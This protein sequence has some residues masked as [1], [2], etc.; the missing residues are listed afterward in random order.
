MSQPNPVLGA[1]NRVHLAYELLIANTSRLFITV[2]KVEA[3]DLEGRALWSE[4]G[5]SLAAM[6]SA[7][8]GT[9]TT[10]APGSSV[11]VLMDVPFGKDDKL[12]EQ[13]MARVTVTR[14]LA[15][16]DG[17][18]AAYPDSEPIPKTVS[19]TG[20]ATAI[21]KP[22][23]LIEPPLRG[24]GWFAV[25]GCCDSMTSHRGAVMAVNGK[26]RVPERFAIDWIKLDAQG[27]VFTGDAATLTSY[28]YFG[29]PVYAVADGV[30]V[31]L[32]DQADEQVPGKISGITTE[33]IGGNMMVIDI[34]DGAYAFYAHLQ[35]DS[36]K[37]KLG[38][39]VT[40]GDVVGLLG[41]TGNTT[42]P[43][44]HFHLMDGTSPLDANGLSYVFSKFTT[45]GVVTMSGDNDPIEKGDPAK[46]TDDGYTGA[47]AAQLPL[48]NQVVDFPE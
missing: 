6:T 41:N 39:R 40:T 5:D 29:A 13:V 26:L 10:M 19:F 16:Q 1:D 46:I 14:A 21:G 42:A 2:D 28:A 35:R 18:P 33:N 9:G 3:V 12:P 27:R 4:D 25:N 47:H 30:V 20:A 22:A 8:G 17:K 11:V 31:N 48:N 7:Y 37:F 44:L 43:H 36:L 15:G 32:Y 23:R 45:T 34:G 24:A 38:D